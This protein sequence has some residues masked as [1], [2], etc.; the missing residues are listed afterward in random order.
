MPALPELR[1]KRFPQD[2]DELH[3]FLDVMFGIDI[4]RARVCPKHHAPFE[5]FCAAYFDEAPVVVWKASR[6]LGGKSTLMGTLV[7]A[8]ATTKAAQSTVLGGSSAQSTRVHDVASACWEQDYSPENLLSRDPTKYGTKLVNGA[9]ILA[10]MASQKSARGPHPQKLRLDEVDEMDLTLF[11]AAQGQP[12]EAI[13]N[14]KLVPA[15]TVISS[16]HQYP[17]KTMTEVLKRASEK[18]WPVY[19]WCYRES[20]AEGKG[21]LS[22]RMIEQKRGEVSKLM[23]DVEYD[24]QEP[25]FEGRAIDTDAIEFCFDASRDVDDEVGTEIIFEQPEPVNLGRARYSTGID[26]AKEQDW[27]IIATFR[28]DCRPWR[29]VA[30]R[31][32]NRLSWPA[33]V[34]MADRRL[35]AYGGLLTHDSTGIGDVVDDY[36]KHDRKQT[37]AIKMVG[38]EREVLLN[39]WISAIEGREVK[40][41]RIQFAY[42]EHKYVRLQDLFGSGHPPDSFVA[43]ACAW[44][45]RNR[46]Y[47]PMVTAQGPTRES[48]W[49]NQGD[50]RSEPP[51]SSIYVTLP[52]RRNG[53]TP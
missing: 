48:P 19:E 30:W 3:A 25:S 10:L 6:G 36:L 4:P 21:W 9:W 41:P 37:E 28:I 26:W 14:G 31:R 42:G 35:E 50:S 17:D 20:H 15:N 13:R 2:P 45:A 38:R 16:T 7:A 1:I 32:V 51:T 44:K 11:E 8:E 27:T 52:A 47:T 22:Q 5:A 12:M 29:L 49:R 33:M 39:D 46:R 18:G 43:F 24:L 23:W 34:A 40:I 53:E